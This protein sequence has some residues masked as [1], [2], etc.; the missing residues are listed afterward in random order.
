MCYIKQKHV[1]TKVFGHLHLNKNS[2]ALS[3]D[4]ILPKVFENLW[5]IFWMARGHLI[6][7][8]VETVGVCLL[9]SILVG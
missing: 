7:Y 6:F 4:E 3:E 5:H 9:D 8:F 2:E 1:K